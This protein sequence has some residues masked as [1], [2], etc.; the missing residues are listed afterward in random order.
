VI[1][2]ELDHGLGKE[3]VARMREEVE[4]NRLDAR[5]ARTVRSDEDGVASRG[6]VARVVALVTALFR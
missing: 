4:R 3:R 5:L 2:T 6:R 1:Y